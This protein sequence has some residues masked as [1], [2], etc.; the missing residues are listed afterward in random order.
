MLQSSKMRKI[1]F[2]N[3]QSRIRV[4]RLSL[5]ESQHSRKRLFLAIAG[6]FGVL[7]LAATGYG[8]W[9]TSQPEFC[10]GCHEIKPAISAW[11]TSLH[12]EVSCNTCHTSGLFG[13]VKQKVNLVSEAYRHYTKSYEEPLNRNSELSKEIDNDGCLGCHT[14]KR[15]ITPRKSLI[16]NHEIHLEKGVNCTTCHNRAG[17]PSSSGYRDFI[18]MDG[19]FRCHG[20]SKTALAPGKCVDVCH[21][22]TFDIVPVSHKIG[23]WQVPDHGKIA[24][25]DTSSC[26]MCHKKTFCSGCH[27]VEVPHPEKFVKAEHGS[28]GNKKPA[29]CQRC[30]RERDFCN[31]CHHKGYNERAGGWIPTH[32]NVVAVAGPAYCFN[33]H[34]PT[35][36]AWCHVRGQKQPLSER[37]TRPQV[38]ME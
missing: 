36:C 21:P 14:P 19:C 25:N 35:Y 22:K 9:Y 2:R 17:H 6:V 24:K 8:F 18:G 29:V 20:L 12:A 7:F 34:G 38:G 31:A 15:I 13:G 1:K 26:M 11:K 37:P 10:A 27:G 3:I 28:L 30:H 33:C 16:M 5:P 4:P 32:K 23:T